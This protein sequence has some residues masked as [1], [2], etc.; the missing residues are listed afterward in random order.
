MNNAE[1]QQALAFAAMCVDTTAKAE[2]CNR[3]E[4]YLRLE[5]ITNKVKDYA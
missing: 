3:Q 5:Q 2:G 1:A 4:M